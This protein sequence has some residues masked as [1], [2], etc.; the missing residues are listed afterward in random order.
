MR[1]QKQSEK[2]AENYLK[3]VFLP[4]K[5][6]ESIIRNIFNF[7]DEEKGITSINRDWFFKVLVLSELR[8]KQMIKVLSP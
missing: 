2:I 3:N 1:S 4:D 6:K 7:F 5:L 8:L